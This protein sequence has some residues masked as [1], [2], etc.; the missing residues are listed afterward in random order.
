MQ[1]LSQVTEKTTNDG[2]GEVPGLSPEARQLKLFEVDEIVRPDY[3]VGKYANVLFA[4]PHQKNLG[5]KREH[6][7]QLAVGDD[8][9]LEASIIIHP[10]KDHIVPTTTSFKVL[11]ALVQLW[12]RQG[13]SPDGKVYFSDRQMAEVAGW[14][15]S[16]QIAKRI[17]THLDVLHGTSIDWTHAY[18]RKGPDGKRQTETKVQKMHLLE[19]ILYLRR[20]ETRRA[21]KF[22]ANH[23]VVLN[24][25]L[26]QNM[27]Q[28]VVRPINYEAL[29][30]IS[31]DVST[32]LYILL[33]LYLASKPRWERRSLD[34]LTE[35]LA[36]TGE[37]YQVRAERKRKLK[38]LVDDLHNTELTNGKL[39]LEIV[40]TSDGADWKLIARKERRIVRKRPKLA[41]LRADADAQDLANE[42]YGFMVSLRKGKPPKLPVLIFLCKH[43]PEDLLRDA[44]SR[45]RADYDP[46][47][48]GAVFMYELKMLVD[49]R[50]SLQW[51]KDKQ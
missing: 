35:D 46:R 25:S 1:E 32:R 26:V 22:N 48:I 28:N 6:R 14:P 51:Y 3:N 50:P 37:R 16:G 24:R 8:E 31:S 21:E 4:S 34:L 40:E 5:D 30:G 33:D 11:M 10:L 39:S 43:Y 15:Y 2:V 18:K 13:S 45:A 17:A 49:A 12:R 41:V 23:V 27:L 9:E 47:A 20:G 36:Y 19:E 44:I 7:W 42:L 38:Q 29:R